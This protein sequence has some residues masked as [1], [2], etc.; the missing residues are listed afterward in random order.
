MTVYTKSFTPSNVLA[1]FCVQDPKDDI[2]L[3]QHKVAAQFIETSDSLFVPLSVLLELEWV[4]RGAYK[5]QVQEVYD[6]LSDLLNTRNVTI[7]DEGRVTEALQNYRMGL[8]FADALHLASAR[9]C[10]NLATFGT[11]GVRLD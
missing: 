4:L 3:K 7:E 9:N 6:V 1:R 11:N 8:D 10:K 5:Y 2:N